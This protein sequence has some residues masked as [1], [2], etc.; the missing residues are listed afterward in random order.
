MIYKEIR[1]KINQIEDIRDLQTITDIIKLRL[2]DLAA[3]TKRGLKIGDKVQIN[4]SSKIRRGTITK[5]NRTR[6]VVNIDDRLWN[7]P[8]SMITKEI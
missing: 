7:V 4:G 2:K 1:T 8:F 5:I 6:A 3:K